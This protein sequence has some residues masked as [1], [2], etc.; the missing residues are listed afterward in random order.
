[1]EEELLKAPPAATD[2][3]VQV[4]RSLEAALQL[5]GQS[6]AGLNTDWLI[7]TDNKQWAGF[8]GVPQGSGLGPVRL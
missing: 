8:W 3:P 1:M 4:R 5:I 7:C 2:L 6:S